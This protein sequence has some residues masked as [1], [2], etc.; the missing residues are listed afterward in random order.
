MDIKV[1]S[2]TETRIRFVVS[3]ASPSLV[4]SLRRCLMTEIPKMAIELVEFHLGPIMDEEGNEY[5]SVSPLFDEIIAHRLGLVPVPTDLSLY[6]PKDECVCG[7]EGCPNCTIMYSINKKGPCEVY[8]GDMEPLGPPELRIKDELI[9][10]VKLGPGQALLAYA[11]AELGTAKRH[12]KWQV[13]SGA[14]YR[15]YPTIEID[16]ARCDSG[17]TCIKACPRGVLAK[18]DGIVKVVDLESCIL[19][20]SCFEVCEL[21]AIKLSGSDSKFIFEFETDGSLSALDTLKEALKILTQKF[22]EFRENIS[23]LEA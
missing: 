8:S 2:Q 20:K 1:I 17:G 14:G 16:P 15:Y 6:V 9:P 10:I 5:E 23:A 7:G 13:V 21:N 22:E 4:N 11:W 18:E 19:C 12:A 3:N